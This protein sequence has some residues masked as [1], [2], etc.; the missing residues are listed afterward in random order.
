MRIS[1]ILIVCM[2][3]MQPGWASDQF[4]SYEYCLIKS[5][6]GVVN[7]KA[8]ELINKACQASF[9]NTQT[10][11]L[12]IIA[13]LED[14]IQQLQNENAQLREDLEEA[15]V[16]NPAE[17]IDQIIERKLAEQQAS[18][19]DQS[20]TSSDDLTV[21][22]Y[23]RF[24]EADSAKGNE[25]PILIPEIEV[26]KSI[27]RQLTMCWNPPLGYGSDVPVVDIIVELDPDGTVIEAKIDDMMLYGVDKLFRSYANRAQQAV[28]SC[29]P[30]TIPSAS[31]EL[32][33]KF[34]LSFDPRLLSN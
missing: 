15:K 34:I 17:E 24:E 8:V 13:S 29:S 12:E 18:G 23:S 26:L 1:G 5:L 16:P 14:D 3:F 21:S 30:I 33:T 27:Q 22:D 25:V 20:S 19:D 9:D 6:K 2:I 10:T 11:N 7:D 28:A 31:P 4:K 32:Y